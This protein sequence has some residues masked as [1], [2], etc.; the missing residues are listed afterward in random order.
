MSRQRADMLA[1]LAALESFREERLRQELAA[2]HAVAA[3]AARTEAKDEAALLAVEAARTAA[4][5]ASRAD[6]ARY[7]L[8]A[9]CEDVAAA[10]LK[11]SAEA[12]SLARDDLERASEAWAVGRARRDMV[13]ERA[14]DARHEAKRAVFERT[15]SDSLDRW[16]SRDYAA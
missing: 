12:S 5:H 11:R 4:L 13:R 2:A 9:M 7:T 8:F 16:L 1:R 14:E 6:M 10:Q 3:D 15:Q